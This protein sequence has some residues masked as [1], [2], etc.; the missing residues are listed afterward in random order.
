MISST[1]KGWD[2]LLAK[3][4]FGLI[5]MMFGQQALAAPAGGTA[6]NTQLKNQVDVSY[7]GIA[8]GSAVKHAYAS[9]TITVELV[10]AAPDLTQTTTSPAN[11]PSSPVSES[12]QVTITY[13]ATS[14]ANGPDTYSFVMALTAAAGSS[15]G[16]ISGVTEAFALGTGAAT[17]SGTSLGT[18]E[19]F[20]LGATTVGNP[21]TAPT[22]D[23]TCFKGGAGSCSIEVPPDN[24]ASASA[25]NGIA[26]GDEVEILHGTTPIYCDVSSISTA[27][28][29]TAYVPDT[30]ASS[31]SVANCTPD[32]AHNNSFASGVSYT[33]SPGDGIY[34]TTAITVVYTMGTLSSGV[35]STT[36][37]VTAV[38]KDSAA[39]PDSSAS[40]AQDITVKAPKLEVYKFVRITNGK[41]TNGSCSTSVQSG[42]YSCL[43]IGGNTYFADYTSSGNQSVKSGVNPQPGATLEYA[44]LAINAAGDVQNVQISDTAPPFTSAPSNVQLLDEGTADCTSTAGTCAVTPLASHSF[45]TAPTSSYT[46]TGSSI[47]AYAGVGGT[48]STTTGGTLAGGDVTVVTYQVTLQ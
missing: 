21:S 22:L 40:R 11:L 36:V 9:V 15:P 13:R 18:S 14:N 34:Q 2:G 24:A 28:A 5:V 35:A 23:S 1:A 31:I 47:T 29:G 10:K 43:T 33:L 32:A 17:G 4:A 42:S 20:S 44:I 7:Q 27:H 45:T 38:A 6:A 46:V 37:T 25:V 41:G 48:K 3:F 8:S 12:Q 19:P 26:Q 39:T 16:D 30:N